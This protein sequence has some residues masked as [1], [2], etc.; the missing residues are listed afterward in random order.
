MLDDGACYR[1][2]RARDARFDGV[3]YVGV[4]TTGIYC[5]PVCPAR[6]PAEARC[7][8]F[9]H[10]AEAER[11]GFRACFR[12]RPELSPGLGQIDAVPR[13]AQRAA[14]KIHAGFLNERS[15]ADLAAELGVTSRHLCRAVESEMGVSPVELGQTRRLALAKQLLQDTTL[16]LADVAF[17]AGFGSVRRFN[18]LFQERFG[19]PPTAVRRDHG[20]KAGGDFITLRMGY[21][22]PFD[23]DALLAFLAAR[24]IPGVERVG[25]GRYARTVAWGE[26]AGWLSVTRDE[27]ARS[28]IARVSL[29]LAPRLTGI[30]SRLRSL[31]D[32]DAQPDVIEG[33][34]GGDELLAPLVAKRPGLRVPGAFDG[35]EIAVRAVLGQQVSVR[36]ATTLSGRLASR[37]GRPIESG[38]VSPAGCPDTGAAPGAEGLTHTFPGPEAL[39]R[40]GAEALRT[41]GLPGARAHAIAE[42]A[43]AVDEGRVDLSDGADPTAT[44]RELLELP[45]I[46]PWTAHYVGMR[47][48]RWP[49]AFPA[50]D[51]AVRKALG[52]ETARAAEERAKP[53]RPWRA[54]AAM[55]LWASLAD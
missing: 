9:A 15:V 27:G 18:A 54:Y 51:L 17:S 5:R 13:L 42:L 2:L 20:A 6:T 35:F 43:R 50:G 46:G 49:D 48:L 22:A 55:H 25:A 53:W 52:V 34:L 40:A 1:A 38:V 31:F 41:I 23:W 44:L 21:R 47:A 32:L 45:G 36:G 3:F 7:A 16:P 10:A 39:A 30:T 12:C 8:F 4:R 37:F 14:T 11:A 26:H 29:S 28:V 33:Q 24:A 19:R